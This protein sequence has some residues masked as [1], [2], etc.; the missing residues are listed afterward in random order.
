ML[1]WSVIGVDFWD[2]LAWCS[3]GRRQVQFCDWS[4]SPLPCCM[5]DLWLIAFFCGFVIGPF[6]TCLAEFMW[7]QLDL[8]VP[9]PRGDFLW[10]RWVIQDEHYRLST[11]LYTSLSLSLGS[12]YLIK[13][14]HFFATTAQW[15]VIV[16][17]C[18]VLCVV[19]CAVMRANYSPMML[20]M[21]DCKTLCCAVMRANY[22]QWCSSYVI[23]K[24]C[25]VLCAVMRANYSPM[26]LLMCDCKTLC[27]A[28]MRANYSPMMLLMRDCKTLCCAVCCDES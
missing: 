21:C 23:V 17:L 20:L 7:A 26:M 24:P 22:T 3:S 27:C 1:R 8:K 18:V 28:V 16:K 13:K 4:I 5:C 25:V 11:H 9:D 2:S 15:C 14:T 19:L 10:S 12:L 6:P